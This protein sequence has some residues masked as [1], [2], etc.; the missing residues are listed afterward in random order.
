MNS[1]KQV[2]A[3]QPRVPAR[4]AGREHDPVHPPQIL[5][6]EVQAAEL[7]R[8]FILIEAAPHGVFHGLRLLENLLEHV[9][10]EAAA[11]RVAEIFFEEINRR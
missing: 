8:R 9:M 3:D 10:F 11:V 2:F 6:I 4:A 1:S 7:G 5:R